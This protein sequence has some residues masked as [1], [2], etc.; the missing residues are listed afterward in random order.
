MGVCGLIGSGVEGEIN[1]GD[2]LRGELFELLRDS[3][4]FARVGIQYGTL[5]WPNGADWAPEA[6]YDRVCATK[7]RTL[8]Q[9]AVPTPPARSPPGQ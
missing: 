8:T 5:A 9:A 4:A 1:L 7:G 3:A 2:G 6:L